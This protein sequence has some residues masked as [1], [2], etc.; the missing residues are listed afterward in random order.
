MKQRLADLRDEDRHA[1]S[2]RACGRLAGFDE[3]AAAQTVM[4][5][6]PLVTEVDVTSLAL[7][8]FQ[9]G[10]TVCVPRVDWVKRSMEPVEAH[11]FDDHVMELD[12]HGI[13]TPRFG[14]VISS[15][16]LDL[17]IVPGLAFDAQG[18]RL[19][20]GGG[21]Y[22]RFLSRLRPETSKV[23]LVFDFQLVDR[24]P[25]IDHDVAVDII[26]TDRRV[27]FVHSSKRG[28]R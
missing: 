6:M 1:A 27:L 18:H 25:R 10:K 20:R 26:V 19:G 8:C 14:R 13:R 3:F 23:A 16:M 7:K 24:V 11:S 22:D 12:E 28:D 21:Y 15:A 5:Y 9:T 4:M 2:L 17:V